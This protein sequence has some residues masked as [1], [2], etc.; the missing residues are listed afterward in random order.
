MEHAENILK[1]MPKTPISGAEIGVLRGYTSAYLLK[2]R[3]DLKMVLVDPWTAVDKN[4]EA[5][6]V[7]QHYAELNQPILEQCYQ[8][9]KFNVNFAKDRT[10]IYRMTSFDAAKKDLEQFNFVFLDA[11]QTYK[12]VKAQ[13]IDWW[14]HI[15]T[16]GYICG[17]GFDDPSRPKWGVKRAVLEF[18]REN[19]L[20]HEIDT[21]FTW[22][23]KKPNVSAINKLEIL[24]KLGLK[25]KKPCNCNK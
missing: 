14:R 2:S 23:I 13:L 22:F 15:K 6:I 21:S 4:S 9:T 16:G 25:K 10:T 3:L 17:K 18:V 7:D 24:K 19:N 12:S 1:R 5:Y 20:N 8:Q 11:D